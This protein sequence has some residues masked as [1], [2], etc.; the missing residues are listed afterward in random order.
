MFKNLFS[1]SYI[2]FMIKTCNLESNEKEISTN[3]RIFPLDVLKAASITAVVSYH[4]IFVSKASY[5]ANVFPLEI[6]FSCFRFCVPVL[7]TVSFVLLSRELE[8]KHEWS[9]WKLLAKR[10]QRLFIPTIFWFSLT[11]CLRLLNKGSISDLAPRLLNGTIFQGSYF[12]VAL[13][14]LTPIFI[15]LSKKV[16]DFKLFIGALFGQIFLFIFI[17]HTLSSNSSSEVIKTLKLIDRPFFVYWFSYMFL[18]AFIWRN[19]AKIVSFSDSISIRNKSALCIFGCILIAFEQY[20]LLKVSSG[21][22]PPFDYAMI[23]CLLSVFVL[24]TCC[25]SIQEDQIPG[26]LRNLILVF[27]N[28]SLGIFCINGILSEILLSI[29]THFFRD[30]MFSFHEI[31]MIK[32]IGWPILLFSC[33]GISILLSRLGL[34]TFVR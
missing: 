14:E 1:F 13:I 23:S 24:F 22:I 9:T 33:L 11:F 7:F 18:G 15:F 6:L 27:S 4:S 17:Q 21:N 25:A 31:L 26:S 30:Y 20:Y 3:K 28:Y 34:R 2:Y 32:L 8:R 16:F 29:G 12:L 5:Q 10:L 19:W